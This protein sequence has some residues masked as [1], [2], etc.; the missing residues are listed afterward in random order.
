MNL[1][2]LKPYV[3][4]MPRVAASYRALRDIFDDGGFRPLRTPHGFEFS[5]YESMQDGTFEPN[6]T[7]FISKALSSTDVFVD[8][9]A[10]IGFY[11]CLAR[12]RSIHTVA[13]EPHP[14]NLR[15]LY[16]NLHVNGW[17]D[18]EIFPVGLGAAPGLVELYGGGT[19][20]SLVEGWAGV[21]ALQ[22]IT[23]P[24][25]TLDLIIGDRLLDQRMLI[26]LDVEGAENEVLSGA[27]RTLAN[28]RE[29]IWL[30][31][32]CL[33]EHHPHGN[34]PHFAR[35]F[36]TFWSNGY[37]A[38]N[39]NPR[40]RIERDDVQRWLERRVR[41]FGSYNTIFARSPI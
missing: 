35:I 27:S 10:N 17:K 16:S 20:A 13:I 28:A 2:I 41:D 29:V 23:V 32:V 14:S 15:L 33:T 25:L 30:V 22:R 3:E 37:H 34:N 39:L 40:R 21:S 12:S 9:G 36:E 19:A 7:A 8:I 38:W 26:K 5:G 31:E 6:E 1:N 18:V 24:L 4:R 11:S